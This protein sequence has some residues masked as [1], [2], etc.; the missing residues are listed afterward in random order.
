MHEIKTVERRL[1]P[2]SEFTGGPD[3]EE[4]WLDV[5]EWTLAH[6]GS[7]EFAVERHA[8]WLFEQKEEE[9]RWFV[10][11]SAQDRM[12]W[13]VLEF[14]LRR[15]WTTGRPVPRVLVAW[16]M[17]A[18]TGVIEKPI[19]GGRHDRRNIF[20]DRIIATIVNMV[21]QV[22]D[23]PYEFDETSYKRGRAPRT[24]CHSVA[25]RLDMPFATVRTIWRKTE[26]MSI[27]HLNAGDS[28]LPGSVDGE[29]NSPKYVPPTPGM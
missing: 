25:E 2:R 5:M 21:R 10:I 3:D 17:N 12:Y 4:R 24:A 18:T 22:T 1:P 16:W 13:D 27:V 8:A 9:L 15:L 14:L 11:A 23:L 7:Y 26:C 6:F 28:H 29:A 20:R 19:R